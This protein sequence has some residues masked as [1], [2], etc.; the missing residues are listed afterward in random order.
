MNDADALK[1]APGCHRTGRRSFQITLEEMMEK[2]LEERPWARCC[3]GDRFN[4]PEWK[5]MGE[6]WSQKEQHGRGMPPIRVWSPG[7]VTCGSGRT[8]RWKRQ[9]EGHEA[10]IGKGPDLRVPLKK[11]NF[12]WNI[13]Y[14]YCYFAKVSLINLFH[15]ENA[16]RIAWDSILPLIVECTTCLTCLDAPCVWRPGISR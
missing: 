5:R 16:Q 4:Y 12:F 2:F 10:S 9:G 6:N 8:G 14:H 11:L 15:L 13:H 7:E 1:E 3:R